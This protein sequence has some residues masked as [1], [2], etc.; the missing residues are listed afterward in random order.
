M[1]IVPPYLKPGSTIGIVCPAGYMPVE[2]AQVCID[3]LQS[4]GFQVKVGKTLGGSSTNYFSGTDEERLQDFQQ[5]LDDDSVNAVLCARGGYGVGRIID[6]I[7]FRK[8]KKNPKWIIGY[9]DVTILLAHIYSKYKI[10]GLHSPMAGAFNDGADNEFI[11]SLKHLLTGGIANYAYAP[12]PYNHQGKAEG[13]LVGGNLSLLV[14]ISGTASDIKTKGKILFLEDVGEYLYNVDRMFRHLKRT[15]KLDKLAGLIIGGFTDMKDTERPYGKPV[16][17][18]IHE[19]T[20]EYD[21]P[22]CFGF[23]VSHEKE[24]FALKTGVTHRL[25][26]GN[27]KVR[28]KEI[29]V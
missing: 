4:W 25:I 21:Y 24:N 16:Y 6:R 3:T 17:D 27:D 13:V 20:S 22:V 5:T 11:L 18:I 19:V 7:D 1:L 12:H 2:R 23:P 29:T 8:F 26:I 15:G 10:A 14:N 9:S 28:L